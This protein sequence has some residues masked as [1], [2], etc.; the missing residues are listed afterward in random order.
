MIR[1]FNV[2]AEFEVSD[3]TEYKVTIHISQRPQWEVEVE[4]LR[5]GEEWDP[6]HIPT[7]EDRADFTR[8][9]AGV[10]STVEMVHAGYL[11]KDGLF[12]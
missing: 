5:T 3:G 1:L 12:R 2:S 6:F 9:L 10:T 7:P 11:S 8:A 4:N